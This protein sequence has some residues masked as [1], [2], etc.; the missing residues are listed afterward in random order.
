MSERERE[1]GRG[2]REGGNNEGSEK[3]I[4]IGEDGEK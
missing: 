4:E 1:K 2:K 3:E